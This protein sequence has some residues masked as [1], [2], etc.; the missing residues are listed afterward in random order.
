M[1]HYQLPD[2][3]QFNRGML[4]NVG[5]VES[6]KEHKFDCFILH[7]VDLIPEDIRNIYSCHETPRHMSVAINEF[8]YKYIIVVI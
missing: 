4:F 5:F 7:D 1:I 8:H 3:G 2:H 6:Q